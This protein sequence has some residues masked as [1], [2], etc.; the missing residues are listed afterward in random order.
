MREFWG[1]KR[2]TVATIF[3]AVLMTSGVR[4]ARAHCDTMSGPVVTAARNAL[5]S[6]NVNLVL[7]WV[8][9]ADEAAIG[10]EFRR[11][12][13]ERAAGGAAQEAAD[14]RFFETLV[15]LHR[16]GEGAPYTGIKPAGTD[17]GPAVTAADRSLAAGS[18]DAV[19]D[20]VVTAVESGIERHFRAV[21]DR[22]NY[23]ADDVAAGRAYVR[24]YV[25]YTHFAE[26]LYDAAT[27]SVIH[28][29]D[30]EEGPA[31]HAGHGAHGAG[32]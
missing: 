5:R 2:Q 16:A 4:Y 11:A 17:V 8:Q 6:G 25:E 29:E 19:R 15:R 3:A 26:G 32:H 14:H 27:A 21:M 28:H 1:T 7:I 31:S 30:A 13:T 23:D 18:A 22:K 12:R 10:E 20:V 9:P 24:A